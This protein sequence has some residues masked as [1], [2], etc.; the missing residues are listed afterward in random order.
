MNGPI[1]RRLRDES[2]VTLV[3]GLVAGLLMVIGLVGGIGVFESSGH[4][5]ASG[6][7][8][9]VAV[10]QAQAEIERMRAIPYG[11]LA[12]TTA[13]WPASGQPGNPTDRVGGT[14]ISFEHADGDSEELA[15]D[16]P[17]A[18]APYSE[19]EVQTGSSSLTL[20]IYRFVSWRDEN[21]PVL[22]LAGVFGPLGAVTTPVTGLLNTI[23]APGGVL[24]SLLGPL[25]NL[26]NPIVQGRLNFVRNLVTDIR[27]ELTELTDVIDDLEEI[28]PCDADI[29]ALAELQDTL[30]PL[31]PLLT[32]L[33]SRINA[34]NAGCLK[35]LGVVI[36]CPGSSSSLF[37]SLNQ[38]ITNLGNADY[39][40]AISDLT[41][42]LSDLSLADHPYNTKRVTVAVVLDPRSSTGPT[43]PVWATSVITDPDEGLLGG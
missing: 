15:V 4:E 3:E 22:D 23:L 27:T 26:L 31:N 6:E 36:S 38:T 43:K 40:S 20:G 13:I 41:A 18:V 10:E 14:P 17:G 12:T 9:Q 42:S 35:V 29:A 30:A 34:Y 19:V 8:Q 11:E 24:G 28:D 33:N 16:A 1:H 39:Q 25:L 37:T 7:R 5:S 21:C 32:Q 2:G